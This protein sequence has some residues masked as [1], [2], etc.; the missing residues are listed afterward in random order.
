VLF[1]PIHS[2]FEKIKDHRAENT[3]IPLTDALMSVFAMFSLRDP[4]LLTESL[5]NL[6]ILPFFCPSLILAS[7]PSPAS[8]QISEFEYDLEHRRTD[9]R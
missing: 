7:S 6:S 1:S 2:G 5:F 9:D 4:S 8:S 3:K